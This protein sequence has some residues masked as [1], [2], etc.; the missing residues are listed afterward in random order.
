MD[1]GRRSH[2]DRTGEV[3][4]DNDNDD[5]NNHDEEEEHHPLEEGRRHHTSR[6]WENF[7]RSVFKEM[8]RPLVRH[9]ESAEEYRGS[10][11]ERRDVLHYYKTCR[12]DMNKVVRCV[13]YG[14]EEDI[15]RWTRDILDPAAVVGC[16]VPVREQCRT[17]RGREEKGR[18]GMAGAEGCPAPS[19]TK[20]WRRTVL[21]DSSSSEEEGDNRGDIADM[22]E[23]DEKVMGKI[24]K[25]EKVNHLDKEEEEED[26]DDVKDKRPTPLGDGVSSSIMSKW[27]KMDYYAARMHKM[28]AE[29]EMGHH[30]R[31]QPKKAG[32][33][34]DELLSN[35]EEKYGQGNQGKK[36]KK[37]MS[38]AR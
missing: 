16:N 2:Y 22:M 34:S 19:A 7:F 36:K 32:G 9:A 21:E 1:E 20:R 5:G 28:M 11:S 3:L 6:D 23:F 24:R 17:T 38:R 30:S 27:D 10:E 15:E 14:K 25:E 12:G 18:K 29:K 4:E 8:V 35:L 37:T 33:I 26:D 13:P 31:Q